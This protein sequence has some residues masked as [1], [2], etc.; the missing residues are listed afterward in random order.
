MMVELRGNGKGRIKTCLIV[1]AVNVAMGFVRCVARP[2]V[3]SSS[4]NEEDNENGGPAASNK[5]K[6]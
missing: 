3:S 2:V 4:S 6:T 5:G 1:L